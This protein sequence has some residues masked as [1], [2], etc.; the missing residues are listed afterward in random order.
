MSNP[1]FNIFVGYALEQAGTTELPV[2][3]ETIKRLLDDLCES[4]LLESL[5]WYDDL[6]S[7]WKEELGVQAIELNRDMFWGLIRNNKPADLVSAAAAVRTMIL[8]ES[9]P[10]PA[11]TIRDF[12]ATFTILWGDGH[13][14]EYN[15]SA[16]GLQPGVPLT[17]PVISRI[18]GA[19]HQQLNESL[20]SP[21]PDTFYD[22]KGWR[23]EP[24]IWEDLWQAMQQA[25]RQAPPE[26]RADY[27]EYL[28]RIEQHFAPP[29][30]ICMGRFSGEPQWTS[31]GGGFQPAR[32]S[33]S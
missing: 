6:Q 28:Q 21:G 30:S 20:F 33:E 13:R 7:K 10:L 15:C 4:D 1:L 23:P 14:M 16:V 19:F 26:L 2:F 9:A 18:A 27:E 12:Q 25:M 11:Q 32:E 8:L 24:R 3:Q 5:D 31:G 22:Q 29:P 17:V